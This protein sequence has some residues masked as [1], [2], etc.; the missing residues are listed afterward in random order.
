MATDKCQQRIPIIY[1]TWISSGYLDNIWILWIVYLHYHQHCL[2][3]HYIF[4]LSLSG[5]EQ[6]K[7]KNIATSACGQQ[8]PVGA[9]PMIPMHHPACKNLHIPK[10]FGGSFYPSEKYE[11]VSWDHY[12]QYMENI[13]NVPNHQPAKKGIINMGQGITT[14]LAAN[15]A[16]SN[17]P[18]CRDVGELLNVSCWQCLS[19]VLPF[20]K[21][22]FWH[23][24]K[25]HQET[26]TWLWKGS[27][28]LMGYN[29][30]ANQSQSG[31]QKPSPGRS[32]ARTQQFP[33][34]KVFG[35]ENTQSW[36][37]GRWVR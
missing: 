15:A 36:R 9:A 19:N 26:Q 14:E 18:M 17:G 11:F 6:L 31:S 32:S 12:S 8:S 33:R 37:S 28:G 2:C 4:L 29:I 5:C 30:L 24:I 35:H 13:Y 7:R 22:I 21:H 23:N 1:T 20:A 16:S 3:Y 34:S 10:L 27:W 25:K